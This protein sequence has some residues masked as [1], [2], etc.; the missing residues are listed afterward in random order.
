MNFLST[1]LS[2]LTATTLTLVMSAPSNALAKSIIQLGWDQ[3]TTAYVRDHWRELEKGPFDGITIEVAFEHH[4]KKYNDYGV[5]T[6]EAWPREALEKALEDLKA[7]RFE[8]LKHNFLRV[9]S[10]PG[11]LDWFNDADWKAAC[12]NLANI[13]WLAKE[14]GM[15][16]IVFDTETYNNFQYM[17]RPGS[18]KSF[19]ETYA[20]ARERGA[21]MMEA[22]G[23]EFPDVTVL[24]LWLFSKAFVDIR[25][26]D[27]TDATQYSEYGLWPA[28]INGWLDALPKTARIV[29]GMED[30]YYFQNKE[31]FPATYA[32]LRS[33]NSPLISTFLAPENREKYQT[34]VS[35]SF[36]I[37]LDAY[38]DAPSSQFYLPPF[39]GGSSLHRLRDTLV[40]AKA[41]ADDYVWVYNE[42]VRW[43]PIETPTWKEGG[44]FLESSRKRP[45]K[46][47]I[48]EEAFPG[49][50]Q[51]ID[52][53]RIPE[54]VA[55]RI[56][57]AKTPQERE[58]ENLLKN[59]AFHEYDQ[60]GE[61]ALPTD[62]DTWKH[63]SS[64]V[65]IDWDDEKPRRDGGTG[66]ARV[67]GIG[68]GV[69]IQTLPA[70]PGEHY[71][72]EAYVAQDEV[73]P[74]YAY[75]R[76]L[77]KN[78]KWN[79]V[80]SEVKLLAPDKADSTGWR[81]IFGVVTVP[82]GSEAIGVVLA[83]SNARADHATWFA[84]AA[85]YRINP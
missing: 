11:D 56:L 12:S 67:K 17:W 2:L 68:N 81:R 78:G 60:K 50:T 20:K 42:Q 46:G 53:A 19:K 48:A 54:E 7:A 3:P 51:S 8:K 16:G 5:M 39:A 30:G 10:T 59:G 72:I 57:S 64:S 29:E 27:A 28:V 49:I 13:A 82:E 31:E 21:Q 1:S 9:N 61:T 24:S 85:L 40:T 65:V 66:T 74:T 34:Q 25:G 84:D 18:G 38:L 32:M 47:R 79:N 62:W 83:G 58:D 23:K 33:V 43:W 76:W 22:I 69:L 55:T 14:S 4:G 73:S 70:K 35:I 15:K 80:V 44:R 71:A 26:G 63:A 37:Y 6:R 36:G 77:A 75:I 52:F 41:L 45:G